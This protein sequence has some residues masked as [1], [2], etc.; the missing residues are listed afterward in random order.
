MIVDDEARSAA[1][2]ALENVPVEAEIA[3]AYLA[4]P[5][6]G[7]RMNRHL[8]GRLSRVI[9][10][11]CREHGVWFDRGELAKVLWF[12]EEGGLERARRRMLEEKAEEARSARAAEV[13][14]RMTDGL[15]QLGSLE[16]QS[17]WL[18]RGE[19]AYLVAD[20][21]DALLSAFSRH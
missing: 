8:Y 16:A 11:A 19:R 10:D 4:C 18:G 15:T 20:A 13:R 1:L 6:C 9:V 12:V 17:R 3:V 21:L 5:C 7:T 2:E 14:Q